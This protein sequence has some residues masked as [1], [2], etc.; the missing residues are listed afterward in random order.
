MCPYLNGIHQTLDSWRESRNEDGW[1][2]TRRELMLESLGKINYFE[3]EAPSVVEPASRLKDDL[4]ALKSMLEGDI[5]RRSHIRLSKSGWVNYGIGDASG[6]G[7]GATVH[8]GEKLHYMYG[9]WTSVES[10]QTSNYRELYNL[11][12]EVENYTRKGFLKTVNSSC[13]LIIQLQIMLTIGHVPSLG[14]TWRPIFRKFQ[15]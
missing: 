14:E 3:K 12:N 2:L 8:I 15:K 11:V 10:E 5:P 7:Y 6:N 4:F 9:Q 13:I 1:K